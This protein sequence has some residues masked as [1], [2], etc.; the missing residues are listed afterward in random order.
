M[1]M[2]CYVWCCHDNETSYYCTLRR[3]RYNA[4]AV[5]VD[6]DDDVV[7]AVNSSHCF[8]FRPVVDVDGDNES[9]FDVL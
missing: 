7:G 9:I 1:W 5:L 8:S 6:D 4:G 2:Y 3:R